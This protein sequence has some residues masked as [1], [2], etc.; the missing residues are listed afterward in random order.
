MEDGTAET[1]LSGHNFAGIDVRYESPAGLT[2]VW[3]EE[4]TRASIWDA[5]HRKETFGVSGPIS[6]CVSSVAGAATGTLSP[7]KTG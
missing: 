3:A 2:G 6:K 7:A 1:R 4:N 5:M